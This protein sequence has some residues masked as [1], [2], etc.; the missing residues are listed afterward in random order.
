MGFVSKESRS[1]PLYNYSVKHGVLVKQGM[2]WICEV[3]TSKSQ[4]RTRDV[5]D[6]RMQI[7]VRV[8]IA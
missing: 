7:K 6:Y 2:T 4:G 3:L 1:A 8:L 5:S